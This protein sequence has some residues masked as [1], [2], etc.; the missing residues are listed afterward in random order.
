MTEGSR[1]APTGEPKAPQGSLMSLPRSLAAASLAMALASTGSAQAT[2]RYAARYEQNCSLCHQNPTGGG[3]RSLYASQFLVPS[4]FSWQAYDEE[5]RARIQPQLSD[6][7]TVGFDIRTN[8][9]WSDRDPSLE[10]G[11]EKNFF[12]MQGDLYVAVQLDERFSA[13]MDRG[14]SSSLEYFGLGYLLPKNGYVKVGRFTPPF[15]WKYEDHTQFTRELL[16]FRPP[17]NTDVGVEIGFLPAAWDLQL[18]IMNGALGAI[19]DDNDQVAVMGRAAY[20]FR[21]AG[22]GLGVGASG[23]TNHPGG[24]GIHQAAGPFWYVTRGPFTW[25]GEADWARRRPPT[26]GVDELYTSH[27][28]SWR[29]RQ[30]LFLRSTY[31]FYDPDIDFASGQRTR[32]GGGVEVM[33]APFVSFQG[34]ANSW[35]VDALPGFLDYY[36]FTQLVFQV[37]LLY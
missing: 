33:P 5:R 16:A 15:G 2:P 25:L 24:G 20:R 27:E 18:A 7:V 23:W 6:A 36:D 32:F 22:F 29:L 3:M 14:Q 28:V 30:G 13:Y 31:S 1:K 12:Q 4:E 17:V 8:Y 11:F 34:M 26:G 9:A 37:H 10:T 21:W 35:K 19:A